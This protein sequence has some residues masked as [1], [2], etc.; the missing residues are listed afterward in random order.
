[1]RHAFLLPIN[2]DG[3]AIVIYAVALEPNEHGPATIDYD[4]RGNGKILRARKQSILKVNNEW[5]QF[6]DV[7][8]PINLARTISS[9]LNEP[10]A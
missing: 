9:T 10:L 6:D 4:L 7:E 5:I 2:A 1:M 8:L 3:V